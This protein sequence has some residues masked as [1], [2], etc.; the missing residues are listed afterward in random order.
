MGYV[1]LRGRRDRPPRRSWGAMVKEKQREPDALTPEQ[2]KPAD[3][4]GMAS[5]SEIKRWMH[6]KRGEPGTTSNT[7]ITGKR[8]KGR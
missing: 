3:E 8:R 1:H 6:G 2:E 5:T 4:I 7:G